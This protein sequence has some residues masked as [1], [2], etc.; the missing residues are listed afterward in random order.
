MCEIEMNRN[1]IHIFFLFDNSGSMTGS[2][3]Q[4]L[5]EAMKTL[6]PAMVSVARSRGVTLFFHALCFNSAVH[7]LNGSTAEQGVPMDDFH[8]EQLDAGGM[9][10][11]GDAIRS[12]LPGLRKRV[13]GQRSFRPILILMTD[14]WSYDHHDTMAAIEELDQ[15]QRTTRIAIG[16]DDYSPEELKAFASVGRVVGQRFLDESVTASTQQ[17]LVFSVREVSDIADAITAVTLS[18][19]VDTL[20][21]PDAEYITVSVG[22]LDHPDAEYNTVSVDPSEWM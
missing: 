8:W 12:V 18:S 20:D 16:M 19:M 5:N 9:T 13:P 14:G 17:S 15:M 11:T 3:I 6:I 7:W 2:R 21:H 1:E 22:P 4:N 10:C